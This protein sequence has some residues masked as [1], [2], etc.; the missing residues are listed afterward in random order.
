MSDDTHK[1]AWDTVKRQIG[2]GGPSRLC[3]V[4]WMGRWALLSGVRDNL[5]LGSTFRALLPR[6]PGSGD[7]G[8]TTSPMR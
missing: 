1:G 6:S 3:G 8:L 7:S 2:S 5:A 4:G